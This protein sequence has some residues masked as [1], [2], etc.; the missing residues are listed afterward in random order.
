MV[1][2]ICLTLL[3]IYRQ[4]KNCTQGS[5]NTTPPYAKLVKIKPT[6]LQTT[7][8]SYTIVKT[9]S[10]VSVPSD[11]CIDTK[12]AEFTNTLALESVK[13]WFAEDH[14]LKDCL[15]WQDIA[16]ELEGEDDG[17]IVQNDSICKAVKDIITDVLT[18]HWHGSETF[19]QVYRD[20]ESY[21]E[22][23]HDWIVEALLRDAELRLTSI[24][25]H[26]WVEDSR[27]GI[28]VSALKHMLGADK[29]FT[30]VRAE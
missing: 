15:I 16:D 23:V 19:L 10:R 9:V 26:Y 21:E 11:I 30:Y 1:L 12:Y 8:M 27:E 6:N 29:E 20:D 7:N 28:S 24:K 14:R 22:P 13:C 4:H 5:I 25:T 18:I 2:A 3:K 17:E